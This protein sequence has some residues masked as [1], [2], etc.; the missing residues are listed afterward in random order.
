MKRAKHNIIGNFGCIIFFLF[1]LLFLSADLNKNANQIITAKTEIVADS[2][3]HSSKA[4][5]TRAI[6]L[7]TY[8]KN[9]ILFVDRICL[10]LSTDN[11]KII[12]YNRI[13]DRRVK[14][15]KNKQRLI[16]HDYYFR[17]IQNHIF[18]RNIDP[19]PILS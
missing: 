6:E 5:L 18:P 12:A 11:N 16:K 9:L 10:K 17:I 8:H 13:T 15:I 4:T 3:F 1:F 19:V 2:I 14:S 7:P